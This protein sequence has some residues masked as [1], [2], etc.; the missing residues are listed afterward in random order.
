MVRARRDSDLRSDFLKL[1]DI[2]AAEENI[3]ITKT[4]AKPQGNGG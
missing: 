2:R 1:P 4:A 3:F